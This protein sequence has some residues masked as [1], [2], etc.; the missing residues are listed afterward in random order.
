MS[1]CYLSLWSRITYVPCAGQSLELVGSAAA[2]NSDNPV[3]YFSF[4]NQQLYNFFPSTNR[5]EILLFNLKKD[6]FVLK[7][8]GVDGQK[9][10]ENVKD[11]V[12][13]LSPHCWRL[14]TM[15]HIERI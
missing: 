7:H 1:G 2:N 8:D 5:W 15:I 9:Q 12:M 11:H 13:V 14:A 10:V 6:S 3:A 4:V